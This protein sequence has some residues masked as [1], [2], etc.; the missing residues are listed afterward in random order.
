MDLEITELIVKSIQGSISVEEREKLLRWR[1]SHPANEALWR[2]LT[3]ASY[4]ERQLQDWEKPMSAERQWQRLASKTVRTTVMKQLFPWLGTVAA[5]L[6]VVGF[7]MVYQLNFYV[8]ETKKDSD[9][10]AKESSFA[11]KDEVDASSVRLIT[12]DGEA[13]PLLEKGSMV[14]VEG[15]ELHHQDGLLSYKTTDRKSMDKE[16]FNTIVV[17]KGKRYQLEL[18]DGTRVWM[19]AGSSIKYPVQFI[20]AERR[21]TLEGEAYFEVVKNAEKPFVISTIKSE[22]YVLGTSFNV[23][24]YATE[25]ADRTT[26]VEGAVKITGRKKQK[27]LLLKAGDE[28]LVDD[29]TMTKRK[30][31]LDAVL[32]WKNN[33]FIF[34]NESLGKLMEVLSRHYA[35]EIEFANPSVKNYHF[36]GRLERHEDIAVLLDIIS[37]TAKV[38]FEVDLGKVIVYPTK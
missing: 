6:F 22:I 2:R 14:M 11:S 29:A 36:S 27:Q 9:V 7:F 37:Q 3:D 1:K 33:L 5:V 18:E 28:A 35:V 24:A 38:R 8:G 17:P 12:N 31:D 20:S 34:R 16:R 13:L 30:A 32:A 26:L 4:V 25:T 21:V 23:N 19:N 15:R 10:R